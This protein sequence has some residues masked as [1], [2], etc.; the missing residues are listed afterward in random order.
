LNENGQSVWLDNLSRALERRR[1][2]GLPLAGLASVASFF[3]SRIDALIDRQ[4]DALLAN[5]EKKRPALA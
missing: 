3:L 4:L 2:D 5:L 1:A